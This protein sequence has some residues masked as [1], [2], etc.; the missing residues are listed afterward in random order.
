MTGP[1]KSSKA[2]LPAEHVS[3]SR[4]ELES[5]AVEPVVATTSERRV[6]FRLDGSSGNARAG[7]LETGHGVVL[8]PAFMPVGTQ[9][10][11][12]GLCAAD[13]SKT[14]AQM[15]I[16]NTYHLW[17]RPGAETVAQAGGL[18]AFSR[19]SGAI[20]TDSGGFQAFSLADRTKVTEEGFSFSSHLDGRKL[21]LSPEKA[22][23][24]QGLLGSDVAMQLDV[25]PAASAAREQLIAACE[26]TTRWAR[27]CLAARASR[28]AGSDSQA[29]F[30][31]VQGGTDTALRLAHLREL[32]ALDFEGLALGGFSVGET[33]ER[34]HHTL[35]EVAPQMDP[36]R[37]HY[38][39]GVGT[40]RDLLI[41]IGCGVDLFDCVMPTR[42]ARNG[43]AF[44]THG[45]LVIKNATYKSDFRVLDETCDCEV[46][47]AGYSRAFLRHL[48]VSGEM[49]VHQL[50]SHHNLRFY[51]RLVEQA[52]AAILSG[53]YS[54]F[55]DQKLREFAAS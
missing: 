11:V 9:A 18:H 28:A 51:A 12:K 2:P 45:K 25:C 31:I 32:S 5:G 14:G 19:L 10:S 39:M 24:I 13:V 23:E 49:L 53:C 35:A 36:E 38:L 50:M 1:E 3:A 26:R 6:R 55:R 7:R 52:R 44:V 33:P 43:Q 20:A 29:L 48:Y 21:V 22:M 34:M 42:N 8:T 16:M 41:A 54:S 30:G 15:V 47:L 40:P 37:I 27:R 4:G 17:L 46:C